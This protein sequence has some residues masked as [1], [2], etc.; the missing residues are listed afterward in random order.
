MNPLPIPGQRHAAGQ[1][2]DGRQNAGLR[3]MARAFRCRGACSAESYPGFRTMVRDGILPKAKE[4]IFTTRKT[5]YPADFGPRVAVQDIRGMQ[6]ISRNAGQFG[7]HRTQVSL[8]KKQALGYGKRSFNYQVSGTLLRSIAM[9]ESATCMTGT[10]R[11]GRFHPLHHDE[12]NMFSLSAGGGFRLIYW[13]DRNPIPR[14]PD[15][16]ID[17]R[18]VTRVRIVKITNYHR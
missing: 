10:F 15:G 12:E 8:W 3:H 18:A 5:S 13:P 11:Q 2:A 16:G 17:R 7:V 6:T 1:D 14:L 4:Y 9:P